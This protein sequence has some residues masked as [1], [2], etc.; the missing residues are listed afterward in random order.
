MIE[1]TE[2]P[3]DIDWDEDLADSSE[4]AVI[5]DLLSLRRINPTRIGEAEPDAPLFNPRLANF[6]TPPASPPSTPPTQPLV[7]DLT[8]S[9]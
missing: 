1:P 3:N 8:Q 7:L 4:D 5:E 9:G 2:D 6:F